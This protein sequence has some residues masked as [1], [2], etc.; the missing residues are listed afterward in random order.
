LRQ[1]GAATILLVRLSVAIA[2]ARSVAQGD[3]LFSAFMWATAKEIGRKLRLEPNLQHFSSPPLSPL[4]TV[5]Q[6]WSSRSTF[7][8]EQQKQFP[9]AN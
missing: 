6:L 2:S 5:A 7:M 1:A 9:A 8:A 3:S 4:F